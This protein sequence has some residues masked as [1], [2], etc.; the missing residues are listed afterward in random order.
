M[1]PRERGFIEFRSSAAGHLCF[2]NNCN[3][4][5]GAGG[6]FGGAALNKSCSMKERANSCECCWKLGGLHGGGGKLCCH[7]PRLPLSIKRRRRRRE[8]EEED[9][10]V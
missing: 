1:E 4:R 5:A 10:V 6:T 9:F 7:P 3:R 2:V 8:E